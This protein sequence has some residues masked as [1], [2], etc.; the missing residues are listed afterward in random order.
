MSAAA[1][2]MPIAARSGG[3]HYAG[4]STPDSALIVDLSGMSSAQVNADGTAVIGAGARLIDVYT[5]LAQAGRC[6]PVGSVAATSAS[7][8][9]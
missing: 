5:A 8:H 9:R 7:S 6:L 4:Y 3:H 1:E 2:G